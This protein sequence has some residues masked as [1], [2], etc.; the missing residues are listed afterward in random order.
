MKNNCFRI[1]ALEILPLE[2][3]IEFYATCCKIYMND[4][5]GSIKNFPSFTINPEIQYERSPLL[6]DVVKAFNKIYDSMAPEAKRKLRI[7]KKVEPPT[8]FRQLAKRRYTI[9]RMTRD[10]IAMCDITFKDEFNFKKNNTIRAFGRMC[11]SS[12]KF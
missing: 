6:D 2:D 7:L 5:L 3:V 10:I 12:K 8:S 4:Q 9:N 1:A 11:W